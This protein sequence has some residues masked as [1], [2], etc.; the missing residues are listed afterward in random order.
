MSVYIPSSSHWLAS[1]FSERF[2]SGFTC[3]GFPSVGIPVSVEMARSLG[4]FPI[5]VGNSCVCL[6]LCHASM[7]RR[8]LLITG[9]TQAPLALPPKSVPVVGLWLP[10]HLL[11]SQASAFV[12]GQLQEMFDG[13]RKARLP[14]SR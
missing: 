11:P 14:L 2:L 10:S 12:A 5:V 7:P 9:M 8:C 1:W 13:H 3:S 6:F 4:V